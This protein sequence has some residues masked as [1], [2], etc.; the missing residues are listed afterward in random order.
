MTLN[1]SGGEGNGNPLQYSC[2]ENPMDGGA[3]WATVHGVAKSRTWLSDFTFTFHF[4]A[5]EKEMATH[6]SILAWRIPGMGAWWAAVYGVAQSQTRLTWLSSSSNLSGSFLGGASGK[7]KTLPANAG[8]IRD[9][10]SIPELGRYHWRRE[11]QPT[12]SVLAWKILWTGEP[13]KLQFM[14]LQRVRHN[15][16]NLA[17]TSLILSFLIYKRVYIV[18]SY[19]ATIRGKTD[20]WFLHGSIQCPD[21]QGSKKKPDSVA[22]WDLRMLHPWKLSIKSEGKRQLVPK[23]SV[24]LR[25][26][27]K[28]DLMLRFLQ[29]DY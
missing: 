24:L 26:S 22:K 19:L 9:T 3:W 7:K 4:H 21:S 25:H 29:L 18:F 15:W 14:G 27:L 23:N 17:R 28:N 13:G 8:D 12:P 16:S 6:S 20:F 11:W 5:L 1:L 2:L 10:S